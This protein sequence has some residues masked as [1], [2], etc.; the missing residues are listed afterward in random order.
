MPRTRDEDCVKVIFLDQ[1]V[2]VNVGEAL[3]RVRAPMAQQSRLGVLDFQGFPQQRIFLQIEHSQTQVEAGAPVGVDLS[4]LIGVERCSLNCRA[5]RTVCRNRLIG[6][7]CLGFSCERGHGWKCLLLVTDANSSDAM[8]F[9]SKSIRQSELS[10]ERHHQLFHSLV[11][12]GS[13]ISV[14][15]LPPSVRG[16]I[17]IGSR[18]RSLRP[19][20]LPRRN[21]RARR[22]SRLRRARRVTPTAARSDFLSG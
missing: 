10:K 20:S 5:R 3:A 17:V 11:A 16:A 8:N 19:R 1:T 21:C 4:Q 14:L 2:E 15:P 18:Y 12:S 22:R 9:S 13:A 7:K 6:V